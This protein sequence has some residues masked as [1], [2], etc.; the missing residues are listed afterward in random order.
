[1]RVL[2]VV[3]SASCRPLAVCVDGGEAANTG[4]LS[5]CLS[6]WDR[7][8]WQAGWGGGAGALMVEGR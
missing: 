1:M 4:C 7:E 6:G 2:M 3:V 8:G 5:V